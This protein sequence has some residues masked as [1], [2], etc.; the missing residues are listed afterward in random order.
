VTT[1]LISTRMAETVA[2]GHIRIENGFFFRLQRSFRF[3]QTCIVI[4]EEWN[5]LV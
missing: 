4:T 3:K 5:G 1:A 2:V